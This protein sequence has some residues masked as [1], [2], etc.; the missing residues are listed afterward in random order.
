MKIAVSDCGRIEKQQI[1]VE[2]LRSFQPD[3]E[4]ISVSY[5]NGATDISGYD[6]LVL[7]GGEDVDPELSKA[8]PTTLVEAIDRRRDDFEMDLLRQAMQHALPVLGI[9]RGLQVANV[10]FGGTLIA[11]LPSAGFQ[12]H[13]AKKGDPPLQHRIEVN[14]GSLLH[15]I[16]GV[17]AGEI[18]SFHHQSVLVP[19]KELVVTGSSQDGV[20][21]SMEWKTP[22]GKP[23]LLLVQWHPERMTDRSNPFTSAVASAFFSETEQ[24]HRQK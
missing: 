3:A 17:T 12:N 20:V 16:T 1:Y 21:E 14:E 10:Y 9:C 11:D 4:F 2:W 18:N 13:T 8:S 7:S 23:F 5:R 6:G 19:A 24:Y 15:S 22:E